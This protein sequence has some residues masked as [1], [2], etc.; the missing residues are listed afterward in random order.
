MIEMK[1]ISSKQNAWLQEDVIVYKVGESHLSLVMIT[2]RVGKQCETHAFT[3]KDTV[4]KTEIHQ[5]TKKLSEP[6]FLVKFKIF[7][8]ICNNC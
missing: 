7:P 3:V 8:D 6:D 1:R 2:K 4:R 5:K